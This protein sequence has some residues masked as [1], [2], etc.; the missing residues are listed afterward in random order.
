MSV[1]PPIV[2]TDPPHTTT[3]KAY[4]LMGQGL[5]PRHQRSA[6]R[7]GGPGRATPRPPRASWPLSGEDARR[8]RRPPEPIVNEAGDTSQIVVYPATSPQSTETA[9]LVDA[10][11]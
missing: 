5:R 1:G 11:R 6:A 3:R 9:N 4:D 7:C 8:R 10:L 2:G